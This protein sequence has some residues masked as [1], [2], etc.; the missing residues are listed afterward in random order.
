VLA[1]AIPGAR[2]EVLPEASHLSAIEQPQAF[3][4]CVMGFLDGL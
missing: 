1:Q 3:A 4:A 2:L